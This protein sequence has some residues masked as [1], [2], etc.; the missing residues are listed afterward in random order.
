MLNGSILNLRLTEH[1]NRVDMFMRNGKNENKGE[2]VYVHGA[3]YS[4]RAHATIS[5]K[6]TRRVSESPSSSPDF[7]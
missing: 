2:T 7:E 3:M 1:L 5:F 4:S 6:R